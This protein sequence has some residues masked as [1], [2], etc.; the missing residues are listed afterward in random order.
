MIPSRVVVIP[1]VDDL[2]I[3]ADSSSNYRTLNLDVPELQGL[4]PHAEAVWVEACLTN[5]ADGEID[6]NIDA[7]VGYDRDHELS[8]VSFFSSVQNT[9]ASVKVDAANLTNSYYRRHA[10]LVLKWKATVTSTVKSGKISVILYVRT[11]GM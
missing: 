9:A 10:R 3:Y 1:L 8:A 11:A 5:C 7:F 2:Q 6:W 4:L